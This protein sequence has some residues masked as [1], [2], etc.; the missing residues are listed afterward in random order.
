[1]TRDP[2][3]KPEPAG[4][5]T[6]I[7]AAAGPRLA[8]PARR[9]TKRIPRTH[10]GWAL[11]ALACPPTGI[12]AVRHARAAG[13]A[14]ASGDYDEARTRAKQ[15]RE[16]SLY[17][18]TSVFVAALA[19]LCVAVLTANGHA[20][21]QKFFDVHVL[22]A[23]LPE[24]G[25]GFLLNAELFVA[26]E[27][28]VL[29]WALVV[30]LARLLPG[31]PAAPIRLLALLYTDLFRAV[32]AVIVIYLIAFGLPIANL[33]ILNRLT[34]FELCVLA[35]TLVY[36]AYVAEVYRAGVQ[37]VHWSQDAAAR[38]LGLSYAQTLRHVII[39]QAV[40]R[41]IPPLLNDF[42]GLQKD[43]SLVSFVGLLDGFNRARIVAADQFN[44]SAVTGIGLAFV[45]I[46]IPMARGVDYLVRRDQRRMQ[47]VDQ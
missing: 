16:W 18:A 33:P 25:R 24:I 41:I 46:T 9:R 12:V 4:L 28:L 7:P 47:A 35:L 27:I 19:A 22:R 6:T 29:V 23:S 17:S 5:T 2:A 34:S 32:P 3:T 21:I 44:L 11:L 37:S 39:P 45:A 31:R 26:A 30:A 8:P 10:L 13:R 15:A 36:G 38:G 40:R 1:M 14:V 20:V 43:T 42:I